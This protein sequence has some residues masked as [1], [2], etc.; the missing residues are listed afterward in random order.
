MTRIA[1]SLAMALAM[2]LGTTGC[3]ALGPAR[4]GGLLSLGKKAADEEAFRKQVEK[5]PFPPAK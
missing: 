4:S 2:L 5:D 3:G 1:I